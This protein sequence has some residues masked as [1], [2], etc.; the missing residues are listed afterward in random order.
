MKSKGAVK[1]FA[2]A[3]TIVCIFQLSFTWVTNKVENEAKEFANGDP[4][5]EREYLDSIARLP[6]YNL[7]VAEFTYL[8]CKERELNLGLDLQGGMNVTLEVSIG[9]LIRSL[10]NDNPDATFG[11]AIAATNEKIK[12]STKDYV[13]LFGESYKELDPN[14][15]LAAIFA[16]ASNKDQIKISSTNEEVLAYLKGEADQA[17]D[18]SFQILRAR[19]DKF[20]V[21]Q[22]NIQKLEGSGRILVELPGVDN[23]TRVRKLLQGTAKLEF[24]ETFDNPEAFK[25]LSSAND[26]LKKVLANE[27]NGV[28]TITTDT[29]AT[30]DTATATS[31][32]AG[33]G[34]KATTEVK[35]DSSKS[36]TAQKTIEQ[37]TK[38]N[39]L[40]VL[41]RPYADEQ[42][43][44]IAKGSMCGT[45]LVKDTAK[46]NS[47]L[48]LPEVRAAMP[49]N[50]RF[51]W[52]YKGFG[53]NGEGVI[54][55][56]V[57]ASKDGKAS[58]EGDKI[59][60]ARRDISQSGQTEVSMS[61]NA[62]G[63]NIWRKLTK[64]NVGHSIAIVLDDVVYSS[65]N[66]Q[67][68]IPN[69]RS[70]ISGGFTNEEASDLANILKAGKLPA[71]SRIV[72]E[73]VVG[74]SLG[75]EA[76]SSGL[77]SMVIATVVI[78]IFMV[79][80]YNNSGYIADIAV[81][82]NVFFIMGVLASLGAALT[83]PGIAGIVLTIG[84]AVDA[85]VLINE[86]VKEELLN[87]RS[88]KNAIA[89]GYAAASSSII[90]ANL[91]TLIAG[92]VL[93]TFGTG[94]VQGFAITLIIGILSSMFTAVLLTRVIT[95]WRIDKQQIV[96]YSRAFSERAFQGSTYDW[97]GKRK[98]F[99]IFS[100]LIIIGGLVSMFTK[101]FTLGVD[102]KGGWTYVVQFDKDETA[103]EIREKLTPVFGMA[104][105]VKT[106][107]SGN[108]YKITTTYMIN[109]QS[110]GA[111][112]MV[113]AKLAEGL[114]T[115]G[116]NST[117]LSSAKVGPTIANDILTASYWATIIAL[118]C[119]GLYILVR[120]R[121]WQYALGAIIALAHD[122]L[123]ML[124]FYSILDGIL[125]FTMEV[126]QT[127]IAA[128]LTIIGFS[129]NDTVVVFDRIR[130]FLGT[131]HHESNKKMVINNALNNTL[132]RT[133]I[134]SL[135]V[136]LVT[137]IL[138]LFGGEVIKGF[139]FALLVGIVFGTYSSIAIATP[140][141]VDF[142]KSNNEEKSI[143]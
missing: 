50:I 90:D 34:T 71:P 55:H 103:S 46:I 2:I 54:L 77:L 82:I 63:A 8:Q 35:A 43:M 56:A 74:P 121:K 108:K 37:F 24:W 60:D 49:S 104:P 96:K 128:V 85:N 67:N 65:P 109:D 84:M 18:R 119:I 81:L 88:L 69:G 13:T 11:K 123:M 45:A 68:E 95:E 39:P 94:P 116:G 25:H 112:D 110:E 122:V 31:A 59:T 29:T 12:T 79:V 111:G 125:P 115:L 134:T 89:D 117:I 99:Y 141:V 41:L 36:D 139:T 127:F 30:A 17:I 58:L 140:I 26:M 9:D 137:L 80:Y 64:A 102:F 86:R 120:F 61:M 101:G 143:A 38:E 93:Y 97:V 53:D 129:I 107:G 40:F 83:L 124:S 138:F 106:F 10:S 75:A 20:G 87:A 135:T 22:P 28:S 16:N 44:L 4:I 52:A 113:E 32:L 33:L 114:K 132:N 100:G 23:P 48:S 130:E 27:K 142:D 72:E 62:E 5:K 15:K 19:I 73:A 105:E 78:L 21:T 131:H 51:L 7:G 14:A 92:F 70:S 76:I 6:V 1:L 126:D 136:F 91:T 57:K 133:I 47:Y 66:V 3:L 118:V 42:N 98:R